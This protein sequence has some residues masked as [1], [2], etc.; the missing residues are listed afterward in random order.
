MIGVAQTGTGKTA[1]FVLPML[2]TA[3]RAPPSQAAHARAGRG[4]D[5]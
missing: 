5:A 2:R 1:A 3:R 4:A